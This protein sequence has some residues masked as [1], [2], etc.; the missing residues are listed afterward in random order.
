MVVIWV[1]ILLCFA[2]SLAISSWAGRR[3]TGVWP[4]LGFFLIACAVGVALYPVLS[5][6]SIGFAQGQLSEHYNAMR[7]NKTIAMLG[8]VAIS[9]FGTWVLPRI[10]SARQAS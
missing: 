5:G 4:R 8:V 9:L 3:F 1:V 2:I 7:D 6:L 10:R